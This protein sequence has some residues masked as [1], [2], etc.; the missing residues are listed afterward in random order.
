MRQDSSVNHGHLVLG[1]II[2]VLG[3]NGLHIITQLQ[4]KTQLKSRIP[5]RPVKGSHN[6]FHRGLGGPQGKR[7]QAGIHNVHSRLDGL[8]IDHG[9]HA[10]GIVCVKVNRNADHLLKLRNEPGNIKRGHYPGHVLEAQGVCPHVL[11]LFGLT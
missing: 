7:R 4:K 8:K 1:Q 2:P 11:D 6:R 9:C 10:A 5:G 3:R